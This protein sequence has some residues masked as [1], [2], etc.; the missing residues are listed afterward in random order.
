MQE[1][2]HLQATKGLQIESKLSPLNPILDDDKLLCCDGQLRYAKYLPWEARYPNILPKDHQ[3]TQL[4][5]KDAHE[6]CLHSGTT[7]VLG[8]T[9][10]SLLDT[11]S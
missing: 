10:Q 6:R 4:I 7:Q 2:K 1:I 5:I 9:F 11:V 8:G 3:V